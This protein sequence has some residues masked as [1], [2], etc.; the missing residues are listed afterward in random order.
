MC[1]DFN[2][3]M[4][5]RALI[6]VDRLAPRKEEKTR[7]IESKRPKYEQAATIIRKYGRDT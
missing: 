5:E 2:F 6:S 3:I 4:L 7:D 1:R